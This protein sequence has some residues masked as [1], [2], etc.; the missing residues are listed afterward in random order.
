LFDKAKNEEVNSKRRNDALKELRSRYSVYLKDLS[1]EQILAGQTAEAE[2][3]LNEALVGRGY[4]LAVQSLLEQN[5]TKQMEAQVEFEKATRKAIK[6]VIEQTDAETGAIKNGEKYIGSLRK[7]AKANQEAT[8]T[9]NIPGNTQI[10]VFNNPGVIDE[11]DF[12]SNAIT[13]KAHIQYTLSK[14]D[15]LLYFNYLDIYNTALF[16][17]FP[18]INASINIALPQCEF[19]M[20]NTAMGPPKLTYTQKTGGVTVAESFSYDLGT[21]IMTVAARSSDVTITLQEFFQTV[22]ILRQFTKQ[23]SLN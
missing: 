21:H 22:Y 14:V 15:F 10:I 9:L 7:N 6:A 8:T 23:V 5:L 12:V 17:N 4:A 16:L 20:V 2:E 3:R 11:I 13:L 19:D 18:S 1:D